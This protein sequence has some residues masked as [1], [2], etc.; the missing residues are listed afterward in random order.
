MISR[1]YWRPFQPT[2][3]PEPG[4]PLPCAILLVPDFAPSGV[5]SG[6]VNGL[7]ET[8]QIATSYDGRNTAGVTEQTVS[9]SI[10]LL[11]APCS[12]SVADF[13]G[14]EMEETAGKQVPEQL[15]DF[16]WSRGDSNP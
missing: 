12:Y 10:V 14:K 3:N 13:G 7:L 1:R 2:I 15:F 9:G 6:Q 11:T 5:L 16:W 8:L 4:F